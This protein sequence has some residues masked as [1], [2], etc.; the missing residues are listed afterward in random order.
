VRTENLI[1]D[2]AR[3]ATPVRPLASPAV[4]FAGWSLVAIASAALALLV[5]GARRN[6]DQ[7]VTQPWFIASA[8]LVIATSAVAAFTSLV[9]AVPGAGR[10]NAWRAAA[11]TFLSVWGVLGAAMVLRAGHGVSDASDWYVCFVRVILIGV[12]P[13]GVLF[14][15]LRRAFVLCR[16][17]GSSLAA[18]GAMTVGSAAIQFICPLDV[19][20][21]TFLGHV[22]P[23]LTLCAISAWLLSGAV[24]P[25]VAR[26]DRSG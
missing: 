6:L 23:A 21:H 17:A 25:A 22:G 26:G 18:L 3:R 15:M 14:G 12:I 16:R 19:A 8:T 5:F 20:S 1:A 2:L 11:F 13:A 10:S 9:L 4:R 24:R 7:V